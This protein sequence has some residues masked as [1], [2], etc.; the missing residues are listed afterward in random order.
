MSF[1]LHSEVVLKCDVP[2]EGLFPNQI[3]CPST[4]KRHIS[5]IDAKPDVHSHMQGVG[6]MKVL[7]FLAY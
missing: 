3:G 2:E 5:N 4:M 7:R 1:E 6:K